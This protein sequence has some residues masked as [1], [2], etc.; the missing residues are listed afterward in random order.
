MPPKKASSSRGVSL[1]ELVAAE[2]KKQQEERE[3]IEREKR[4]LAEQQKKEKEAL[5]QQQRKKQAANANKNKSQTQKPATPQQP[6]AKD[7]SYDEDFPTPNQHRPPSSGQ[8]Q[9]DKQHHQD[10]HQSHSSS[11]DIPSGTSKIYFQPSKECLDIIEILTNDVIGKETSSKCLDIPILNYFSSILASQNDVVTRRK[12]TEVI[13]VISSYLVHTKASSSLED[14]KELVRVML[15]TLK[16]RGILRTDIKEEE[17]VVLLEEA[18]SLGKRFE[19]EVS[20]QESMID[21]T[22]M[23]SVHQQIT[24]SNWNDELDWKQKAIKEKERKK[25]EKE[26]AI[27]KQKQKEYEEFL[28]RRGLSN[29]RGVIKVHT[30]ADFK[31]PREIRVSDVIVSVGSKTL[32]SGT[33][34]VLLN[35]RRYGMIGR[36]GVGKTTLLRHIA[37]RDF[38]GIPPYLQILHIEQEIVGD[39]VSALDTVLNSDVERLSLLKEE[40]RLLEESSEDAGQKLAEIYER[41]DEIDAH[42]AE[43]RAAAI[44]TGLQ[45]TPEMMHMKTKSLSGG[46]RMR[47]ALARALFVEP[48]ILLLDEPTNHLDLFAVIWLEEYL[49]KY[50]KTLVVVSHAKR[51][52]NAVVTDIILVKDQKLHYYKGDYDTFEK[53][54]REQLTQ[55][56]RTHEAQQKQRAHIQKFIDRFRY[57]AAT[58]KMAQSRIKVLEKMDFTP[59]VVEDPSFSFTFDSPEQENPPY[60]QAVDVT[61]GYTR[62]KILFKKLNF[63]LDMDSRIALVGPNGTGKSTFLNI[64]AEELKPLEG[65]VNVNRKIRIAKFSQHHMEHLNPQMTPLEHMSSIFTNEKEPALRAQLSKLGIVGDLALQPIYTLSGGQ[66]SRVVFAEITFRKPHLLL[67]DEPSNHLDIDTVDALITALNEYNGGILMVSHDEYLITSVCDEI[68]VCTGKTIS[69][70]NGDFYDYK[71]DV[72]KEIAQTVI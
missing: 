5:Q 66:K 58:A 70:Y 45:F 50:D 68:W 59:A 43:A 15:Q 11:K 26:E 20:E 46:W 17:H 41:L 49:K 22:G 47:V 67:L 32:L 21:K 13:D 48:D 37:E 33:D 30:A 31:G 16:D 65:T 54:R 55:Q 27:I 62:D 52:L 24:E 44:L 23:A 28:K 25:K 14:A 56:Q 12:E 4:L 40:K 18:V 53:T 9:Q 42:S 64:L 3:K 34:V 10:K 39:D 2:K 19:K 1:E 69:K 29:Q 63:N 8:Q 36:N 57:K 38:K 72:M 51:F 71:K 6:T 7:A 35:G 60:L 61:F